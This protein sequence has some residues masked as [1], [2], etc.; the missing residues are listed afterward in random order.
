[1]ME[2]KGGFLIRPFFI[3]KFFKLVHYNCYLKATELSSIR[4]T[5]VNESMVAS[6]SSQEY[7]D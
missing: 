7:T 2:F 3:F 5:L 4:S 6:N 1:M